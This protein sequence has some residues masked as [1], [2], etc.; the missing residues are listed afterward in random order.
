MLVGARAAQGLGAALAAPNALAILSRTFAEGPERNRALGI[1]GAA[2]GTA[3]IGGSVLGGLLVQGPGW[4]WA[5]FLNVPVGVVLAALVLRVVPADPRR[6]SG[7]RGPTCAARVTL[8][9]GLMAIAFGVHQSIEEGW[10]SAATLAPLL[11][12]LALLALFVRNEGRSAAPLIP[13]TTLRKRSV[14]LANL[15][16]GAAVGELPRADLPG[17]AVRPAGPGLLAAGGR[18]EH[19]ADRD[20]L[21]DRLRAGRAAR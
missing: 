13:L 19:D 20:P 10:L 18:G 9:A 2:G 14:V 15:A 6:A 8:T 4:P 3:A 5:F 1:F 11:G 21:A 16:A 12:G 17:H 7:A